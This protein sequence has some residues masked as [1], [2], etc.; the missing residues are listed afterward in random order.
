M[1]LRGYTSVQRVGGG[2]MGCDCACAEGGGEEEEAG[3]GRRWRKVGYAGSRAGKTMCCL[4]CGARAAG[5]SR[6]AACARPRQCRGSWASCTQNGG[7]CIAYFVSLWNRCGHA[8]G[9]GA[10]GTGREGGRGVVVRA[11]PRG[12]GI[13]GEKR[14]RKVREDEGC[15]LL[16][17]AY[18]ESPRSG[19]TT[20]RKMGRSR[21]ALFGCGNQRP[22]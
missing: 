19:T 2:W 12:R 17:G 6:H 1:G 15:V 21:L 7:A 16:G 22:R 4:G 11:T 14:C 5:C 13:G 8:A 3:G 18:V 20:G 9:G 10:V